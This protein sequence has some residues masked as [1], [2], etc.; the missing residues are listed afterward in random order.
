MRAL[1]ELMFSRGLLPSPEIADEIVLHLRHSQYCMGLFLTLLYIL[2]AY[3]GAQTLFGT[4]SEYRIEVVIAFLALIASVPSLQ[5]SG[6]FRMP[7]SFALIGMSFT[8][9][10][11]YIFNG[12]TSYA[13]SAL[14]DFLPSS[15]AF[16]L[17]VL[18]CKKKRHL[19]LVILVL[20]FATLFTIFRGYTALE[21]GNYLSPYV[22]RM[23]SDP[24]TAIYR[25]RGLSFINDPNDL[26]QLIVS[27]IPCLFFFWRP[28]NLPLNTLL[29]LV[30]AG[31]LLFGMF[32]TH[33]R[34]AILALL[35]VVII[36]ARRKI[37][38]I[39]SVIIAGILFVIAMAVGWS[40]GREISVES[41]SDRIEAWSTGLTL[42]KTHPIFGVGF[43]RFSEYFY[44]TAHNTV[45]VCAA[46]LGMVGLFFWAMF[47]LPS[48][49]DGA[50]LT[51]DG[52]ENE[53]K[54]EEK[55]PFEL[56]FATSPAVPTGSS[57]IVGTGRPSEETRSH[58]HVHTPAYLLDTEEESGQISDD[59]IRRI[60]RLQLISLSGFLVAGW[61]LSRAY[62]MTL[63]IYGG[64]VEVVF[65]MALEKG[66]VPERMAFSRVF[67]LSALC[68]VG[69]IILV[70]ILLRLQNLT[71]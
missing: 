4:L 22:Y 30:P 44:I 23:G 8:V 61:F 42:L 49:L 9:F 36:A 1:W 56:S 21:E 28:K 11:S 34:G 6:L 52:K 40:G 29:V 59:E 12:L 62:V 14:F 19:Q 35:A 65:R 64:M 31:I 57:T 33:S 46:E 20:V 63:F 69:L 18:N 2:T 10:V 7:Q 58:R 37:G 50:A 13:P 17:I 15:F 38:T 5:S 68:A 60:G 54:K 25:L 43:Q 71:R 47:V 67:W 39:P 45:V 41:G 24:A 48:F 66:L 55:A 70:Y 53:T 16:F 27:L 3:L 26:A 51:R 32:L